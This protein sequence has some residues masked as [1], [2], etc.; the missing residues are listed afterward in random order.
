MPVHCSLVVAWRKVLRFSW[1]HIR[2]WGMND[3]LEF[4][5]S[6]LSEARGQELS[7]GF[8]QHWAHQ[9]SWKN[10][11]LSSKICV[12]PIY[13]KQSIKLLVVSSEMVVCYGKLEIKSI[14][15][16]RG[17]FHPKHKPSWKVIAVVEG[18]PC[19]DKVFPNFWPI[20][21]L[22]SCHWSLPL[23]FLTSRY[24]EDALLCKNFS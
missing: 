2:H 23:S 20:L 21:I 13:F 10:Y 22:L 19:P 9:A 8:V 1:I 14:G 15:R 16:S 3:N 18:H 5:A 4:A 12:L 24:R 11:I 7:L 17:H 6:L